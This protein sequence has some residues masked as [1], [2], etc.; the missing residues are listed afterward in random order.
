[1]AQQWGIIIWRPD[2]LAGSFVRNGETFSNIC[3]TRFCLFH[4]QTSQHWGEW[5]SMFNNIHLKRI[6]FSLERKK[7]EF[8]RIIQMNVK[9]CTNFFKTPESLKHQI[10]NWR[11]DFSPK[12]KITRNFTM[13]LWKKKKSNF[14]Q[15][16]TLPSRLL[17]IFFFKFFIEEIILNLIFRFFQMRFLANLSLCS[18]IFAF[19]AS[20][21]MRT[22]IRFL[23]LGQRL[24][25]S[26]I[27]QLETVFFG[28]YF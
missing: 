23:P 12:K 2:C 11:E 1:M 27:S 5:K 26:A 13:K 15:E 18:P 4:W 3:R 19:W 22:T 20:P 24:L 16:I 28:V 21:K 14:Y 17:I 7:E 8:P 25:A 9:C 10:Q 6:N